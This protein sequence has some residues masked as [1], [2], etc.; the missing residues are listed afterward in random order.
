MGT[1]FQS[2]TPALTQKGFWAALTWADVHNNF[3]VLVL[4]F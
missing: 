2:Q 4:A 3:A 1:P